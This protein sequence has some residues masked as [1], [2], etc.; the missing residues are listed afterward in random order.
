MNPNDN[1]DADAER[2]ELSSHVMSP[3]AVGGAT[4]TVSQLVLGFS[5]A[6]WYNWNS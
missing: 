1:I 3:D 6:V 5:I 4:E 2:H